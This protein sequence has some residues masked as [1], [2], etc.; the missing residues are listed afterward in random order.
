MKRDK[1]GIIW[2]WRKEIFDAL[3]E[4]MNLRRFNSIADLGCAEAYLKYAIRPNKYAGIDSTDQMTTAGSLVNFEADTTFDLDT[5]K[6]WPFEDNEFDLVVAS[7]ILEHLFHIDNACTEIERI[8]RSHI[9]IGLPNDMRWDKRVLALFG[10]NPIG[11]NKGA[12]CRLFDI[13]LM[14]RWVKKNFINTGEWEVEKTMYFYTSIGQRFVPK[15]LKKSLAR[16]YPNIFAGEVY[17]LL[18]KINAKKKRKEG[19]E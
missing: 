1:K 13:P 17:F 8:S 4:G 3:I 12:H 7:Q 5:D 16:F 15:G 2:V 6:K 11:I 19:V 18:R 10:Q 9:L 14:R